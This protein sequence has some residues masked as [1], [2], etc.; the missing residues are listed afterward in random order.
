MTRFRSWVEDYCPPAEPIDREAFRYRRY[1]RG[2]TSAASTR[3]PITSL[4]QDTHSFFAQRD[5][6]EAQNSALRHDDPVLRAQLELQRRGYIVVAADVIR[7]GVQ[8]WIVGGRPKPLTDED[9]IALARSRGLDA[10][11]KS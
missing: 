11:R 9:L 1:Q 3:A 8:G 6:R 4:A 7:P 2:Q 5:L 10:E